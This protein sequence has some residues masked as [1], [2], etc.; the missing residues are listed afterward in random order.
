MLQIEA[1]IGCRR[2]VNRPGEYLCQSWGQVTECERVAANSN[3]LVKRCISGEKQ[4]MDK[5][6]ASQGCKETAPGKYACATQQGYGLYNREKS[7]GH[8][9]S[10]EQ[11]GDNQK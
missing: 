3:G 8:A 2:F 6:L 10:C 4:D 1:A 7:Q 5:L 9:M 11:A